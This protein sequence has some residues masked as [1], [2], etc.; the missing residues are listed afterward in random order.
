MDLLPIDTITE[1]RRSAFVNKL[2]DIQHLAYV[3]LCPDFQGRRHGFE[4]G[5]TN[6]ASERAENSF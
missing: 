2:L 4:S 1:R 5:G 6:S 3:F